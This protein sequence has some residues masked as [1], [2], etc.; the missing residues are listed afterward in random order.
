MNVKNHMSK[1]MKSLYLFTG[2]LIGAIILA[3]CAGSGPQPNPPATTPMAAA[4][5]TGSA[6]SMVP[7]ISV[8]TDPKLGPILVGDK[9]MTL[10]A[11]LKDTPDT[12]TCTGTCLTNWP[13]LVT[14]GTPNL[15]PG[16]NASMIGT[17]TLADGRTIV[18]Y[19]HMP[20]YYFKG[21]VA[22][23]DTKGQGIGS[24]WYVVSPDGTMTK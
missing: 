15:G 14:T 4:T 19:N 10:Y 11:W 2:L 17:A 23:G 13:P 22:A 7:T 3:A 12:S 16:V 1:S 9:G 5:P 20:L 18:T 8:V 6:S 21:D 24:V